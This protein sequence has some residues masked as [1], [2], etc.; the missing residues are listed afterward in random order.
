[1]LGEFLIMNEKIYLCPSCRNVLRIVEHE[2]VFAVFCSCGV[3][4]SYVA[5][6]GYFASTVEEAY[7]GLVEEIIK[8]ENTP[9]C[10]IT[11]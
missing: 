2:N 11:D 6:M 7:K 9:P 5:N 8:E 4:K 3:C 1:M 10:H